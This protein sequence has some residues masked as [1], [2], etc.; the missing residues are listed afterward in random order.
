MKTS[1]CMFMCI[2]QFTNR[3]LLPG[4]DYNQI[5]FLFEW[6]FSKEGYTD[7]IKKVGK[8]FFNNLFPTIF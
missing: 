4:L 7:N 1:E 2:S 5:I 6:Q 3:K 8:V